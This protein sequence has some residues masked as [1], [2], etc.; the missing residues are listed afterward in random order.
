V[1]LGT[2]EDFARQTPWLSLVPGA[3]RALWAHDFATRRPTAE[4]KAAMAR[5]VKVYGEIAAK[6]I[7]DH[8]QVLVGTDVGGP[9]VL[10][11]ESLHEEIEKL[12][13][14][15]APRARV[16]RAATADAWKYFNEMRGSKPRHAGVVEPGARADLLLVAKDPMQDALPLVPDGVV[17]RGKW[18]SRAD[19]EQRLAEVKASCATPPDPWAKVPALTNA[20]SY[21]ETVDGVL[22]GVARVAGPTTQ[23]IDLASGQVTTTT[24]VGASIEI[25]VTYRGMAMSVHGRRNGRELQVT[26]TSLVGQAIEARASWAPPVGTDITIASA[27]D[28]LDLTHRRVELRQVQAMPTAAV[29]ELRF[30]VERKGDRVVL[31]DS[32]ND[33]TIALTAGALVKLTHRDHVWTPA[34]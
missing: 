14:Y 13:G 29:L 11:G 32:V 25:S 20:R 12:V 16:V 2:S 28:R 19:L 23:A 15:G 22:V 26:G 9:Y 17:L 33:Q 8:Q 27:I 24:I 3:Q 34:D 6:L 21:L 30:A 10:P 31:R 5:L 1:E 4:Q 7:R 18:H